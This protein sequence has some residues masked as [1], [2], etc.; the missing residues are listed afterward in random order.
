MIKERGLNAINNVKNLPVLAKDC[1]H[2]AAVYFIVN[3]PNRLAATIAVCRKG[4]PAKMSPRKTSRVVLT[5]DTRSPS[6]G[7]SFHTLCSKKK[8]N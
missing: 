8:I 7:K 2:L 3:L 1:G 6:T 4:G 5:A